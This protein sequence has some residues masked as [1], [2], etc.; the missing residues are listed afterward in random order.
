MDV[1]VVTWFEIPVNDMKRA[2]TFYEKVF[3][4]RMEPL[5][6]GGMKMAWF[7][8]DDTRP[9]T[10]GGLVEAQGKTPSREGTT[11]FFGVAD[12]DATLSSVERSGGKVVMPKSGS[13]EQGAI[14]LF[15]DTEGNL[16]ALFSKR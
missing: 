7:P 16:V 13:E 5:D 4:L 8:R 6:M 3:G 15:E 12:I 2:Q 14:A 10:S 9:G 1:N 11:V